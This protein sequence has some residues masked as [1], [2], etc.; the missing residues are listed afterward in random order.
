M[1]KSRQN[2]ITATLKPF[3][4][5]FQKKWQKRWLQKNLQKRDVNTVF[6]HN[7]NPH[8]ENTGGTH[9]P[10]VAANARTCL[11]QFRRHVSCA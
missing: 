10:K 11:L 6:Q 5:S 4:E 2:E 1:F 3:L 7:Q 8:A 9:E